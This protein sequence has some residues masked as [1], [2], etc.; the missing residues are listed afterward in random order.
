[1]HKRFSILVIIFTASTAFCTIIL[2]SAPTATAS[3]PEFVIA[4]T[5]KHVILF[6]IISA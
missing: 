4:D 3:T 5:T 1:M 2:S 6:F